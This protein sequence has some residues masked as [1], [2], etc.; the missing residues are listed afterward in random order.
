MARNAGCG[1]GRVPAGGPLGCAPPRNGDEIGIREHHG[2]APAGRAS[3]ILRPLVPVAAVSGVAPVPLRA[4]SVGRDTFPAPADPSRGGGSGRRGATT[5]PDAPRQRGP[6]GPHGPILRRI[7]SYLVPVW[8]LVAVSLSLTVVNSVL[9]QVPQLANRYLINRVLLPTDRVA[10]PVRVLVTIAIGLFALRLVLAAVAFGR[11]YSMRIVGQRLVYGLRRDVF[12]RVQYLST[13][14][15]I[16]SGVGQIMSRVMN[17]TG[18]VQNFVTSNLSQ[19]LDQLFTFVVSLVILQGADPHLTDALLLFG[20]PIAGSILLFSGR[21][22]ATNRAIRRQTARLMAAVHDALA[23]FVTIKAFAAEEHVIDGFEAENVDLF[24]K[25]LSLMRLQAAFNNTM[26]LVTGTSG[27]FFLMYGGWQVLHG[28]INLGTYVLVNGMR[29][30]LFLPFTSFAGITATYQ[31][32]AAGAERIFEY[33]DTEPSVKDLPGAVELPPVRGAVEF[34]DVV[35]HYPPDPEPEEQGSFGRGRGDRGDRWGGGPSIGLLRRVPAQP[36]PATGRPGDPES[37]GSGPRRGRSRGATAR[38]DAPFRS[39][40]SPRRRGSGQPQGA[41][42]NGPELPPGLAD[43]PGEATPVQ[44][45]ALDADGPEAEAPEEQALPP[46][47]LD[48][49]SFSIRPGETVGLVGPSGGG[50]STVAGMIARFYDCDG[51]SVRIDGHDL[52]DVTLRSLRRQ[53]AVVLQ[54]VYL[55]RA[56]VRD[57]VA[58]GLQGASDEE[59]DAALR[60]A[61]AHFVWELPD[62]PETM[63]GEGGMRLSGGQRQRVAIARALLR[64]PRVLVLDEATSAQDTLSENAVMDALRE[65]RGDMTILVIAHRLSTITHADR[66]LVLDSGRLVEEGRHGEL[67]AAGGLYARLYGAQQ[68]EG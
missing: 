59:I 63:V 17:D 46:A 35:F 1:R 37:D 66:I 52:R 26:G 27:A 33:M 50:K 49:V 68:E 45:P 58:F 48:G 38:A 32:A 22:R 3:R 57:N 67:L 55:F 13:D 5:P 12:R 20:P 30:S 53:I 18:Q 25:N 65:R 31:Q 41:E 62:G 64:N 44:A 36:S 10:E 29:A 54:D 19:M 16:H 47:A 23:G 60:S 7:L 61:N 6:L 39:P 4:S 11:S 42:G 21:L 24:G 56:T 15:Y 2:A 34:R 9:N 14:F 8:P 40:E 43:A 51:G 28:T